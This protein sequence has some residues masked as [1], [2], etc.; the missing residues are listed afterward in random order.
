MSDLGIP[1]TLEIPIKR[2]RCGAVFEIRAR[3]PY[4]CADGEGSRECD[5]WRVEWICPDCDNY[6]KILVKIG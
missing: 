2:C 1:K 4:G 5:F 3:R 6:D